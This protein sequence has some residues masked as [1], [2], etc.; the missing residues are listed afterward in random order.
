MSMRLAT[1]VAAIGL[2]TMVMAPGA[3]ARVHE[4]S[5]A[6][7]PSKCES[8]TQVVISLG[9]H[10]RHHRHARYESWGGARGHWHHRG[11]H[12]G[13]SRDGR[14]YGRGFHRGFDRG[15]DRGYRRGFRDGAEYV[16]YGPRHRHDRR[17]VYA[18]GR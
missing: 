12:R 18:C 10:V 13:F 15:F 8:N 4:R 16:E 5:C 17:P 7:P 1:M 11:H 3:M 2:S 14:A 6:P 9:G